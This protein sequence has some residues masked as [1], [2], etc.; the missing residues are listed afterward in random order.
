MFPDFVT[1]SKN[2]PIRGTTAIGTVMSTEPTYL[3]GEPIREGDSVRVYEWNGTVEEI[4]LAG[5]PNWE[6][7]WKDATGEGVMLVGPEFGRLFTDFHDEELLF[8]G[9][10]QRESL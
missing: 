9:R 3:T 10:K 5:C 4:I 7:Y 8:L 1:G 2:R 6:E